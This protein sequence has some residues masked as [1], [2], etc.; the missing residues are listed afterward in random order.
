[1]SKQRDD[2]HPGDKATAKERSDKL[3]KNKGSGREQKTR[4][5]RRR[6]AELVDVVAGKIS[7]YVD[8]KQFCVLKSDFEIQKPGEQK[9]TECYARVDFSAN[10]SKADAVAALKSILNEIENAGL[11]ATVR[12]IDKLGADTIIRCQKGFAE[13]S[14]IYE[15]LSP[16]L[17]AKANRIFADLGLRGLPGSLVAI[18]AR[19][20]SSPPRRPV[21]APSAEVLFGETRR[22]S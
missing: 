21:G 22:R 10:I 15:T 18:S 5:N 19:R 14:A 2:L 11:P 16:A 3:Q 8:K 9:S 17:Q 7:Y 12:R 1:M 4:S 13:A 6:P 20:T